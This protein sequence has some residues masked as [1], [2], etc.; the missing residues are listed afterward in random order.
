MGGVTATTS[1]P[2]RAFGAEALQA[3]AELTAD[4]NPLHL[5]ADFAAKTP[6]GRP[7]VYGTLTLALVWD[8]LAL[9]PEGLGTDRVELRFRAPVFVGEEVRAELLPEGDA[10]GR[11]FRVVKR[12]GES[13]IEGRWLAGA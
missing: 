11:A 8:L 13:A 12:S 1:G 6:L 2:W 9:P 10:P 5:D 7:I 4:F 3:Y